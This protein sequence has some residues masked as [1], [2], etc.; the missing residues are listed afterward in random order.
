MPIA[1]RSTDALPFP[2][3]SQLCPHEGSQSEQVVSKKCISFLKEENR[4]EHKR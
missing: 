4:E 1:E 3:S 2:M